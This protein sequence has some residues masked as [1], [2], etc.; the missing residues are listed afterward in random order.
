M[1][2]PEPAIQL[3]VNDKKLDGRVKPAHGEIEVNY[4]NKS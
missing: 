1:A 4:P 3:S 2:G